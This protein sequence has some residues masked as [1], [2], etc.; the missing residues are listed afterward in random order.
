MSGSV[1]V[2]PGQF[3]LDQVTPWL[4]DADALV[5]PDKVSSITASPLKLFE[6]MAADKA[7]VLRELPALREILDDSSGLFFPAGDK[8]ALV[9]A[10]QRLRAEPA[11]RQRLGAAARQRSTQYTYRNRAIQVFDLL[12][13]MAPRSKK[14]V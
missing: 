6:Y 9:A 4:Y 5:I 12:R 10:L 2:I 8:A 7:S 1:V 3:A 11:L 13:S 14:R